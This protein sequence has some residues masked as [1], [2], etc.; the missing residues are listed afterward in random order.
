MLPMKRPRLSAVQAL[1]DF[2]LKLTFI[3]VPDSL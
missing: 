2:R 3:D 1:S